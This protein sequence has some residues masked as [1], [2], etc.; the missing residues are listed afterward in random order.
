MAEARGL[1]DDDGGLP[2]L[3]S[4]D[5]SAKAGRLWRWVPAEE[6]NAV[7][8]VVEAYHAT[9]EVGQAGMRASL[10]QANMYEL[11]C[12]SQRS[13]L[14]ALR[15]REPSFVRDAVRAL[16]FIDAELII[17]YRDLA[18]AA[19]IAWYAALR[20]NL[21]PA[22]EAD[23]AGWPEGLSFDDDEEF[24]PFV[25]NEASGYREVAGDDGPVL[26][27]DFLDPYEPERDLVPLALAVADLLEGDGYLCDDIVV[28]CV[29]HEGL[30]GSAASSALAGVTGVVSID[31]YPRDPQ[32]TATVDVLLAEAAT[33]ADAATLARAA[34]ERSGQIGVSAGRYCAI[35]H[36]E[37]WETEEQP[38]EDRSSLQRFRAELMTILS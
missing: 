30:V 28:G 23:A 24:E 34:D 27:F 38:Q 11:L 31:T 16:S 21:D 4:V 35:V 7:R 9:G 6:D 22:Q 2:E 37:T 25:L 5:Y 3:D 33:D 32:T 8:A 15:T 14:Q 20:Q 19:M 18:T 1:G 29:I 17:D 26:V 36:T 13:A 10:S 12:F